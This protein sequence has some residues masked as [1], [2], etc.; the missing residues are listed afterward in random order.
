MSLR[1]IKPTGLYADSGSATDKT[2]WSY[3]TGDPANKTPTSADDVYLTGDVSGPITAATVVVGSEDDIGYG[4]VR[5]AGKLA[6]SDKCCCT[7]DVP[8]CALCVPKK[9]LPEFITATITG[10]PSA[11]NNYSWHRQ[12][13]F[14]SCW[15]HGAEAWIALPQTCDEPGP[16][17]AVQVD[18]GG[19]GYARLGRKEPALMVN[20]DAI[21]G[22]GLVVVFNYAKDGF[23]DD[24]IECRLLPL[25]KITSIDIVQ[26]GE[27][28]PNAAQLPIVPI[29]CTNTFVVQPANIKIYTQ[30]KNEK[31]VVTASV[32]PPG[33][34]AVLKVNIAT[35]LV[36]PYGVLWYITGI[37]IENGGTG[38]VEGETVTITADRGTAI[39]LAE[40]KVKKVEVAE[41]TVTHNGTATINIT[42]GEIAGSNPKR[43]QITSAT[44]T[45]GGSGY[46]VIDG[47]SNGLYPYARLPLTFG[48]DTQFTAEPLVKYKVGTVQPV[49][50]IG[51]GNGVFT[52]TLSEYPDEPGWWFVSGVIIN[53]PGTGY[54]VGDYLPVSASHPNYPVTYADNASISVAVVD[55]ETGAITALTVEWGG[56]YLVET[57]VITEVVVENP[58]SMY[59]GS[60]E[61][62]ELDI[63]NP[64]KHCVG[65]GSVASLEV[66]D[67]GKYYREDKE[68]P[69]IVDKVKVIAQA[70]YP[71]AECPTCP[72]P[73]AATLDAVIQSD[74]DS[75]HFGEI[76]GVDVKDG[77][78]C[79]GG[80]TYIDANNPNCSFHGCNGNTCDGPCCGAFYNGRAMVLHRGSTD[81]CWLSCHNSIEQWSSVNH[82]NGET[83]N[84]PGDSV[85][86]CERPTY[87]IDNLYASVSVSYNGPKKMVTVM[88]NNI[89]GLYNN[90]GSNFLLFKSEEAAVSN[91]AEFSFTA[92]NEI[93]A[94]ISITPGGSSA[95]HYYCAPLCPGPTQECG[96]CCVHDTMF[97][98][99]TKYES[100]TESACTGMG[101]FNNNITTQWFKDQKCTDV[102][103]APPPNPCGGSTGDQQPFT[104]MNAVVRTVERPILPQFVPDPPRPRH[105]QQ[106]DGP[107]KMLS[108]QLSKIGINA[109]P[110]CSCQARAKDMDAR[111]NDW[112]EQNID[113]IV[114]W[115]R[116]E[117]EKRRLP[118]ID[119]AAKLLV[120]R[121]IKLSRAAHAEAERKRNEFT[122]QNYSDP[123]TGAG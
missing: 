104:M 10:L 47:D 3:E 102:P 15:G 67:G 64:G 123:Q 50:T 114:G 19:S 62:L 93:G 81:D 115:L 110:G 108:R 76:I 92:T 54:N 83:Y 6:I 91:C 16:A 58:G 13:S 68:L 107:G 59:G 33:Q 44:L 30:C 98:T 37:D 22:S 17:T 27:G 20:E 63:I 117:A 24:D 28:Y 45:N 94:S 106:P 78:K 26:R 97:N 120:R 118:F 12:L 111:G 38:Y 56:Y 43:W 7:N 90:W 21:A 79:Y 109:T 112:C 32:G 55:E 5:T 46:S 36:P 65:N 101:A 18:N 72:D 48:P 96:C 86:F 1:R 85:P 2:T 29:P 31:P 60:G 53:D 42:V 84:G 41:P 80:E 119:M 49:V 77:G 69:P 88:V 89:C 73:E 122:A 99:W 23:Q 95:E 87:E 14:E 8:G 61:I 51:S 116:E 82:P 75:A 103:C 35:M 40:V 34:G 25:W 52:A 9:P 74:V 11:I 100:Y 71:R 105:V 66:I 70:W 113:I 4:L 121:A 39:E 57:G